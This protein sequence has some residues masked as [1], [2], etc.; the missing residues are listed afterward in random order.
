MINQDQ[1]QRLTTKISCDK[2]DRNCFTTIIP[3]AGKGTRLNC[4]EGKLFYKI[5]D[6]ALIEWVLSII[7]IFSK[8]VIIVHAKG[9]DIPKDILQKYTCKISLIEQDYCHGTAHAVRLACN[10]IDTEFANVLWV[11]SIT[12]FYSNII[13]CLEYAQINNSYSLVFP[14]VEI[15]NPYVHFK[16]TRKGKISEVLF[17]RENDILPSF[18][19]KDAGFFI[20][21]TEILKEVLWNDKYYNSTLGGTTSEYNLLSIFPILENYGNGIKIL[22]NISTEESQDINTI[23]DALRVTE[24]LKRRE[25]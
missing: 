15:E 2:I 13:R 12:L 3:A 17:K 6:K 16:I 24:I 4:S 19:L 22:K 8:E 7:T 25:S 20:F 1:I 9:V 21:R 18:G 14:A 10:D 5:F 11:D 23:D